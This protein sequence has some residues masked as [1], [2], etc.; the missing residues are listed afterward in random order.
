MSDSYTN[1]FLPVAPLPATFAA[2]PRRI[3]LLSPSLLH[4][5]CASL[6][7]LYNALKQMRPALFELTDRTPD[8]TMEAQVRA[9][10]E[11]V[12]RVLGLDKC[13]VR[14]MGFSYYV[15]LH[16]IVDGEMSVRDGH[17]IAHL[18]ENKVLASIPQ[19]SEVLVHI[20]P[21]EEL[22]QKQNTGS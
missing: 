10:A 14:K 9:V 20:E 8:P 12:P 11:L 19:I 22:T 5:L 1:K 3:S 16:V 21:E 15:D 17:H 13:H 7:I 18:V 6:V 2:L 4:A